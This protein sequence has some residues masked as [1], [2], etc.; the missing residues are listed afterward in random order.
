MARK[1]R[2]ITQAIDGHLALRFGAL[3]DLPKGR[4]V[5]PSQDHPVFRAAFL[6]G[7]AL[8]VRSLFETCDAK[9]FRDAESQMKIWDRLVLRRHMFVELCERSNL[10]KYS[11]YLLPQ[12]EGQDYKERCYRLFC[13]FLHDLETTKGDGGVFWHKAQ[14]TYQAMVLGL[15]GQTV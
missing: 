10:N 8:L 1:L 9:G 3:E 15:P 13:L 12:Q 6:Q 2:V 5:A 11:K 4:A 14:E 7:E